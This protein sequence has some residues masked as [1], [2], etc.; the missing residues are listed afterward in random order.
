MA[1]QKAIALEIARTYFEGMATN[2]VERIMAVSDDHVICNS[3]IGQSQGSE[4]FRNF[5]E[6]FA[7]MIKKLTLVAAFGDERQA[8]IVYDSETHPVSS[9]LVAEVITVDN[10]KMIST[11]V[12]YDA[13]P[14]A[15]YMATVQ[16]H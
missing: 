6:G 5:Q 15:A 7:K 13:T 9:A 16:P 11:T 10:G 12:I 4:A 2:D 14:F 3:P 1:E 8:V